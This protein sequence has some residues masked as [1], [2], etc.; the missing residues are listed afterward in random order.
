MKPAAALFAL[1]CLVVTFRPTNVRGQDDDTIEL[2]SDVV[3]VNVVA[4]RQDAFATGFTRTDFVVT[5]DGKPQEIAFFG[6]ESTP[7]AAAVL[8]DT[9]GSMENKLTIARAAVARFSDRTRRDD[10]L[11]VFAFGNDVRQVQDFGPARREVSDALWDMVADGNTKIYDCVD[12]AVDALAKRP[13]RR[14]AIILLSDGADNGSRVSRDVALNKALA[15]GVT[16]YTIDIAPS[17]G[18]NSLSQK[19]QI[20][21]RATLHGL[22]DK[23]GGKFFPLKGGADLDSAFVE[24]VDELGHQYTIG[25]YPSNVRRDGKWRRIGV[26]TNRSGVSLR[27]REGYMAPKEK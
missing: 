6:A 10:T 26:T 4:R 14:R 7:F 12:A 27:A 13:E 1:L 24:I 16:I 18:P 22:S 2:R 23:S 19:D 8:L 15:A 3:I 11:S 20:L 9:S 5:E 21:A 17:R 25:Y